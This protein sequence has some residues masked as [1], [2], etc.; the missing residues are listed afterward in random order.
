MTTQESSD[1]VGD[2]RPFYRAE[3]AGGEAY[4]RGVFKKDCPHKV[5]RKRNALTQMLRNAWLDGW[6]KAKKDSKNG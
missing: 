2:D 5:T 1:D 6:D 3:L 4:R